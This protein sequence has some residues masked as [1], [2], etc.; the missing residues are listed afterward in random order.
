MTAIYTGHDPRT[1][2]DGHPGEGC[3]LLLTQHDDGALELAVRPGKD[4][5]WVTWGPP[6]LLLPERRRWTR[7]CPRTTDERATDHLAHP[8]APA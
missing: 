2:L 6:S 7:G 3:D 8:C 4:N 1:D 5:R